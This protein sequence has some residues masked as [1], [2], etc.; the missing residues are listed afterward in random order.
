M[1]PPAIVNV[2]MAALPMIVMAIDP[3]TSA[4]SVSVMAVPLTIAAIVLFGLP[5]PLTTIPG[6]S[7][8]V[9]LIPVTEV[10]LTVSVPVTE[11][12]GP[13]TA[14]VVAPLVCQSQNS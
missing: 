8:A 10:E 5:V 7:P 1:T 9:L 2:A 14:T 6:I 4:G 3:A 11:S 13:A 12:D